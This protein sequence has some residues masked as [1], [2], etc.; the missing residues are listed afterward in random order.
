MPKSALLVP[1]PTKS[2]ILLK[3]LSRKGGADVP[4]LQAATGWQPHSVRATLSG[5]RK[6]GYTIDRASPA[7][8]GTPSIYRITGGPEVAR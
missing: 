6:A 3:L 2:A 4:A 7:K 1:R 8:V 5:L